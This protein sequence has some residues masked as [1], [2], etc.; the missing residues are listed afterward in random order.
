MCRD[1]VKS[2]RPTSLE[3][4]IYFQ[5]PGAVPETPNNGQ[6]TAELLPV[7][8]YLISELYAHLSRIQT[9]ERRGDCYGNDRLRQEH[10]HLITCG[11]NGA[12]WARFIVV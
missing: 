10:L 4:P 12:G 8:R 9:A 2:S 3:H 6:N 7:P 5:L 11:R 1:A